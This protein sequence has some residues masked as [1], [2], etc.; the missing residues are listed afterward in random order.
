LA[1]AALGYA[2]WWITAIGQEEIQLR[3]KPLLGVPEELAVIDI[4][5]FGPPLKPSYKR[6]KRPLNQILNWDRFNLANY[7]TTEQIEQWSRRRVIKRC[8]E[9]SHALTKW[10]ATS[11][12][13]S[14]TWR[15]AIA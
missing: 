7:M 12:E 14:P 15:S 13:C 6:W 1:A 3:I 4:M 10:N 9:M 11:A 5:C 8:T 2:V